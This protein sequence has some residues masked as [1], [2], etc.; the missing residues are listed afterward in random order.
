MLEEA[1]YQKLYEI[2]CDVKGLEREFKDIDEEIERIS[3]YHESKA[4]KNTTRAMTII[5]I[6]C[7]VSAIKDFYEI[8]AGG[9]IRERLASSWLELSLVAQVFFAVFLTLIAAALIIVIPK[10]SFKQSLKRLGRKIVS[11][12]L[13]KKTK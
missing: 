3:E 5:S 1:S 13:R 10:T 8:I 11:F 9:S 12:I 4:N 7:A 6:L 2:M